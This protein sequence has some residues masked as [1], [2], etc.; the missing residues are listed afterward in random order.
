[1]ENELYRIQ[2][3]L[4]D[5]NDVEVSDLEN[6][7]DIGNYTR[8]VQR[9]AIQKAKLEQALARRQGSVLSAT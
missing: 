2:F 7:I 3:V 6:E 9:Y 5:A 1:L 8:E 4:Q